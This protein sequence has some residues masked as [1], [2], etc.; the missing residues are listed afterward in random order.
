LFNRR[1]FDKQA[2]R[3]YGQATRFE[4]PVRFVM[5]DIDFFKQTADQ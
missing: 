3:M 2:H 5:A 1:E 4:H